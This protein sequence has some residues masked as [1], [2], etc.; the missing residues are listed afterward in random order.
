M[1]FL[2][3]FATV[4]GFRQASLW[5]GSRRKQEKGFELLCATHWL[6]DL[7]LVILPSGSLIP[8]TGQTRFGSREYCVWASEVEER[9]T[10][11]R[12]GKR[13]SISQ[14]AVSERCL[15]KVSKRVEKLWELSGW[16]GEAGALV[17][18]R[19]S[20]V[21]SGKSTHFSEPSLILP[22][23]NWGLIIPVSGVRRIKWDCGY[24]M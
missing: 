10:G 2:Y 5:R 21:S 14:Q 15:I 1:F 4:R 20:Y 8:V 7:E 16:S 9:G 18:S 24:K 22:I 17:L 13:K 3:H 11:G 23:R 12:W 19:S 6:G